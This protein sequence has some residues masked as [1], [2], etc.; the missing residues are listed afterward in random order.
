M[1]NANVK[2]AYGSGG[3]EMVDEVVM[4]DNIVVMRSTNEGFLDHAR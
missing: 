2:I 1:H 4:G 3:E